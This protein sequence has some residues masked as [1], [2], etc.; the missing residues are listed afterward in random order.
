MEELTL[1]A[2]TYSPEHLE[3]HSRIRW[4]TDMGTHRNPIETHRNPIETYRDP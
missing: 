1:L 3:A 2:E 4:G